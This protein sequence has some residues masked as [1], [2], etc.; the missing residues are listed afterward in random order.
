VSDLRQGP[1]KEDGVGTGDPVQGIRVLHH[2]LREEVLFR[3]QFGLEV[4]EWREVGRRQQRL[5]VVRF[6]VGIRSETKSTE[7]KS[8]ETKASTDSK[9]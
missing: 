1:G 9:S 5:G 8:T 4:V 2:R 3:S 6:E 7:T